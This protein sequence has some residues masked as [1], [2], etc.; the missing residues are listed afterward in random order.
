LVEEVPPS[1]RLCSKSRRAFG[2]AIRGVALLLFGGTGGAY[3]QAPIGAVVWDT[4]TGPN[5]AVLT[6]HAPDVGP[7]GAAWAHREGGAE[8]LEGNRVA[9][10][11]TNGFTLATI[12]S[13]LADGSTSADLVSSTA[14]VYGGVVFR[15]VDANAHLLLVYWGSAASGQLGLFRRVAGN[16]QPLLSVS[17]PPVAPNTVHRIEA[18]YVG[19]AIDAVLDGIVRFSATVTD[20]DTASGSGLLWHSSAPATQ[21]DNFVVSRRPT[22]AGAVVWDT[23]TGINQTSIGSH[24]PE[25][26]PAG[27]SW[28][29]IGLG[30]SGART[31]GNRAELSTP[32]NG[33]QPWAIESGQSDVTVAAD[34]MGGSG[35]IGGLVF[36]ATSGGNY[37]GLS[38]DGFDLIIDKWVNGDR[39]V[40]TR[41]SAG[42]VNGQTYRIE[43]RTNGS[44][45]TAY[46]NGLLKLTTTSTYLQTATKHGIAFHSDDYARQFDNFVVIGPNQAPVVSGPSNQFSLVS[47][48]V[49]VPVTATDPEAQMLTYSA[50]GLPPGLSVNSSTG[51][52]SGTLTGATGGWNVTVTVSDGTLSTLRQFNWVVALT[53]NAP[54]VM[55]ISNQAHPVGSVISLQVQAS[56]V[57]GQPL[58]YSAT[59]LPPGLSL[60]SSTGLISGTIAAGAL[61][62]YPVS[63][64][65][66]D[67]ISTTIKDFTW[68]VTP[69]LSWAV[70][71]DTFTAANGTMLQSHAVELKPSGAAW[72]YFGTGSSS[73]RIQGNRTELA[74][75]GTGHQPWAIESG[76]SDVVISADF[77]GGDLRI[78][79]LIARAAP[80]GNYLEASVDGWDLLLGRVQNGTRTILTRTSIGFVTG[81]KYHLE[82]RA[83]GTQIAAYV[84]GVI[85]LTTTSTFQQTAT[86][87]GVVFNSEDPAVTF[88][89]FE[90]RV[91]GE[92][93]TITGPLSQTNVTGT[94]IAAVPITATN[95]QN[96]TLTFAASGL[97]AGLSLNTSS[98]AITGTLSAPV[99]VYNATLSVFDGVFAA[100]R[101]LRWTIISPAPAPPPLARVFD[102]FTSNGSIGPLTGHVPDVRPAGASWVLWEG[103]APTVD[104]GVAAATGGGTYVMATIDGGTANGIVAVDLRSSDTNPR[105]GL[106][107]RVADAS[108]YLVLRY[109]GDFASAR[110]ELLRRANGTF[111][112]MTS[113]GVVPLDSSS[114]RLEARM[115][116]TGIGAY[117]D[118]RALF[119]VDVNDNSAFT[120]HGLFWNANQDPSATF[121]NFKIT[122]ETFT[123]ALSTNTVCEA[124]LSRWYI[125]MTSANGNPTVDV[126][127]PTGC[128]WTARMIAGNA[129]MTS[130]GPV[131]GPG[132]VQFNV[133]YNQT[134][135][136]MIAYASV[137]GKLVMIQQSG[138]GGQACYYVISTGAVAFQTDGGSATVTVTPGYPWCSWTVGS[139]RDW[140]EISGGSLRVGPG[141][142]TVTVDKNA[143]QEIRHGNIFVG[144]AEMP[145]EQSGVAPSSPAP[146]PASCSF[147]VSSTSLVVGAGNGVYGVRVTAPEG[148]PWAASSASN[149][150]QALVGSGTGSATM[151][152]VVQNNTA[153]V[154][155]SG[156]LTVAGYTVVV[157]QRAVNDGGGECNYTVLT[158]S[159]TTSFL[160]AVSGDGSVA[161]VTA[162]AGCAW[163]AISES[164]FIHLTGATSGSGSGT[165]SFTVDPNPDSD[166]RIGTIR[167][168]GAILIVS[169]AGQD[170]A[171]SECPFSVTVSTTSADDGVLNLLVPEWCSWSITPQDGLVTYDTSTGTGSL[172]IGFHVNRG[173]LTPPD[174]SPVSTQAQPLGF[175]LFPGCRILPTPCID[176]NRCV[177]TNF[178]FNP[179][180]PPQAPTAENP[181]LMV[182]PVNPVRGQYVSIG[183]VGLG[184]GTVVSWEF[185]GDNIGKITRQSSPSSATWKGVL[186]DSGAV[187]VTW[188]RS[189]Q[190]RTTSAQVSVSA[191]N[192]TPPIPSAGDPVGI[193]TTWG[194]TESPSMPVPAVS[195][196]GTLGKMCL[197][198]PGGF[199]TGRINDNGPNHAVNWVVQPN[200]QNPFRWIYRWTIHPDVD[201]LDCAF[202]RQQDGSYNPVT[203]QNGWISGANLRTN[204]RRHEAGDVESHYALYKAAATEIDPGAAM[205]AKV[206]GPNTSLPTFTTDI[207][208]DFQTMLSTIQS[209]KAHYQSPTDPGLLGIRPYGGVQNEAGVFQGY[210]NF[211]QYPACQH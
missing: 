199:N 206:T 3:A 144:N 211:A 118:G 183:L 46:L 71:W 66:F 165:L 129:T 49:S 116:G 23:F 127:I 12:A 108:N 13:G 210:V 202:S 4:F 44:Q 73:A 54:T 126:T 18:R 130:G 196:E 7:T 16:Y 191:R 133:N 94:T 86:K 33:H 51:V 125:E 180:A 15:A 111:T 117:W 198:N 160:A 87:Q 156:S 154:R 200:P 148:C 24:L 166:S 50:T 164:S 178:C 100:T 67:G 174:S 162:P 142:F 163:S 58:T 60:N 63:V 140:L 75:P 149:F 147:S 128:T 41:V 187:T 72:A 135:E 105:G 177:S 48:T 22:P 106:A 53:N 151:V 113:A 79:G 70:V 153:A 182:Q 61:G 84:D 146:P 96:A 25:V 159:A 21:F 203:N 74:T 92:F 45:I 152:F 150:V 28:T 169:Q 69:A 30:T 192:F 40:L 6:S 207:T 32:G 52:I 170:G 80:G 93:P 143:G 145:V 136:A 11:S 37:L 65:V 123:P 193:N 124:V 42:I 167:V 109:A 83:I 161:N 186:V 64:S 101:S 102:S 134:N 29:Y 179:F 27:A 39:T 189:G 175:S 90:V 201:D 47:T 171:S 59:G 132:T 184:Q 34:F 43:A 209:R 188:R 121:D 2:L 168:Q 98:G 119:Q 81:Q 38:V 8:T 17:V 138:A 19:S 115:N 31:Q 185:Q 114:H 158:T 36:R 205:E 195:G 204:I 155:R 194:C 104:A 26:K 89:N 76:R 197:E 122:T 78:G 176:S 5:G 112:V 1:R 14:D 88:D 97:P 107:L 91:P 172:P 208:A 103:G 9:T 35:R 77:I 99:G 157:T 131:T 57:E 141:S 85:T 190:T 95:P 68:T 55:T 82:L 62:T 110:V 139:N 137:A 56:D 181:A 10:N 120:R 20:Y 173:T